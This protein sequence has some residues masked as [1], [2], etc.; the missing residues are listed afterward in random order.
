MQGTESASAKRKTWEKTKTQFLVR[1]RSGRYYAIAYANG[2][3]IWRSLRTKHYSVAQARLGEFLKDHRRARGNGK[4][5][6]SPKV[7][8]AE[9]LQIH[10]RNQADN[11]EIKPSTL[12]YWN[13]IFAALLKSWPEIRDRE[14]RRI[15]TTD[16]EEW[17]RR[18]RKS[19]SPTR[20]N[21]TLSG[22]RHV[23][24][25]AIRASI[26]Y[27]NPAATPS[28]ELHTP[29]KRVTP[30]KRKPDLPTRAEFFQLVEAVEHAGAGCS[31]HCADFLRGLAFTGVR[32]GEAA[33]IEW[34]DLD[35]EAGEIVVR[36]D[37][38][39]ATK[40]WEVRR[41][42]MIPDAR[43][44]FNR[45]RNDR[46]SESP[47]DKVFR[48]RESQRAIDHA[49]EKL[50]ITRITHHDLRHLF[51]TTCI[52]S[53]IDIPTVSKWLGH[54]D[55]GKLALDTYGHLRN[56]HS[57][58]QAKRVNFSAPTPADNVIQLTEGRP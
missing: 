10:Q 50:G 29:L 17:A 44:L 34:R 16:C 7:T 2:K 51:A 45:M 4:S 25:V 15:T 32:K 31:R 11:V 56:E 27:R 22:L 52:E 8:F 49:C 3:Q 43:E 35:F 55:G 54:K 9:A 37:P 42:P 38:Q 12:H 53:G 20:W 46:A 19:A 47:G 6:V 58:A 18:F 13:Q 33:H 48:V 23:F 1:H 36:G 26:I 5:D 24:D 30:N 39:T 57:Q 21:N 41:V 14:I 28:N 40:N